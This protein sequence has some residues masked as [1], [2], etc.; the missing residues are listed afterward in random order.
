MNETCL[1]VEKLF[2]K[3]AVSVDKLTKSVQIQSAAGKSLKTD[4][5]AVDLNDIFMYVCFSN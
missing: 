2:T 5:E 3:T 1:S 4:V